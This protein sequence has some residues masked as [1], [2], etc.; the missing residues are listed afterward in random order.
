MS[1]KGQKLVDTFEKAQQAKFSLADEFRKTSLPVD[2]LSVVY[3]HDMEVP[4]VAVHLLRW[5]MDDEL[6]F[7]PKKV[8]DVDVLYYT[9]KD[10]QNMRLDWK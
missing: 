4:G 7:L 5:P 3:A 1:L 10:G 8:D 9:R 2:G 6:Q